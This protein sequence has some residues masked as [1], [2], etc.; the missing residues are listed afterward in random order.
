VAALVSYL[1]SDEARYVTGTS[2]VIDGGMIQQ[3]VSK[4]AW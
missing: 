3:V 2:I 1:T 4:P